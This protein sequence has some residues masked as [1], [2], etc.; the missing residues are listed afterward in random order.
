[1][2]IVPFDISPDANVLVVGAGGGCDFI[3]G[4]PIVLELES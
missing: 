3:C 2:S 4:L 1:M